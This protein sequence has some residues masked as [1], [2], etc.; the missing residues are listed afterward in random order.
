MK[1]FLLTFL[2]FLV[3]FFLADKLLIIVRN[4]APDREVDKRME[5]LYQGKINSDI[6][7]LGSSRGARDVIA[8]QLSDSLKISAQNFSF[9]GSGV[10]FHDYLLSEILKNS[11]HKP[12]LLILNVDDPEE[13]NTNSSRL[14]FRLDRFYPFV[15]YPQALDELIKRGEK[16][17][18]LSNLF[19]VHQMSIDNF[20]LRKRHYKALDTVLQDGSMPIS[21]TDPRFTGIFKDTLEYYEVKRETETGLNSFLNIIN[22]CK[23]NNIELVIISP[24]NYYKTIYGFRER[25]VS[26]VNNNAHLYFHDNNLHNYSKEAKYYFDDVHLN[27]SGAILFTSELVDYLRKEINLNDIQKK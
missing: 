24:P 18:W 10:E 5:Q 17:Y 9:P 1:K 26:L 3:G 20:D 11:K 14:N 23:K 6:I 22:Q 27:K 8:R 15:K 12:K 16:N 13:L 19:I 7:I 21:F 25:I 4:S 2:L